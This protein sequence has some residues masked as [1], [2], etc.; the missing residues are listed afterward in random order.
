M[1]QII[2]YYRTKD[3]PQQE[4]KEL[5]NFEFLIWLV[6]FLIPPIILIGIFFLIINLF[7]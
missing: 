7:F 5:S 3:N 1:K 2:I 4:V 6:I